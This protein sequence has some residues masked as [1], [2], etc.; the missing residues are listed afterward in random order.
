M[1]MCPKMVGA[2]INLAGWL[3]SKESGEEKHNK[4]TFGRLDVFY[5]YFFWLRSFELSRRAC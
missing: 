3:G 5:F 1:E 2:L 4:P